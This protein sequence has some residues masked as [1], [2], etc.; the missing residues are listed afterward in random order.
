MTYVGNPFI[1]FPAASGPLVQLLFDNSDTVN[2]GSDSGTWGPDGT[3]TY[4]DYSGGKAVQFS[5]DDKVGTLSP[6]RPT[7][8]NNLDDFT[9]KFKFRIDSSL[10]GGK[11]IFWTL[12]GGGSPLFVFNAYDSGDG[13]HWC[14]LTFA[15]KFDYISAQGPPGPLS[16]NIW[17][18]TVIHY[19]KTNGVV[20]AVLNGS[21][22]VTGAV[23]T[24]TGTMDPI[25]CFGNN[26][27]SI[28][29]CEIYSGYV[30]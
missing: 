22:L 29:A 6:A 28:D 30:T 17:Y 5:T 7:Y 3:L 1:L 11:S 14:R 9:I 23:S 2:T 12:D 26:K 18:S 24:N 19:S 27:L 13:T 20:E 4:I 10:G 21:T 16:Q 25:I 8:L 15:G